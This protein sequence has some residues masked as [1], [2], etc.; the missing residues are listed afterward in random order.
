M[1]IFQHNG[2]QGACESQ[3]VGTSS[4]CAEEQEVRG[5]FECPKLASG[6]RD[7]VTLRNGRRGDDTNYS[8]TEPDCLNFLVSR[9][10]I[11]IHVS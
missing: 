8:G 4:I 11:I 10:N 6:M 1:V 9:P 5:H 2:P 3:V 7:V